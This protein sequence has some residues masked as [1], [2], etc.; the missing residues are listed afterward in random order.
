M[1]TLK[2]FGDLCPR[3]GWVVAYIGQSLVR[4]KIWGAS[5]PKGWNVVSRKKST[6][7]GQY[8]CL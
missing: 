2:I 1:F 4:V 5:T 8:E 3:L 7:V 6:W